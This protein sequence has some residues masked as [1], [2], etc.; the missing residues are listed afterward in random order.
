MI[1]NKNGQ[2][3]IELLIML[4]VGLVV[5]TAVFIMG[6]DRLSWAED[7]VSESKVKI[8]LGKLANAADFVY[9]QSV[10]AASEINLALTGDVKE[11]VIGDASDYTMFRSNH[12]I[13]IIREV[14]GEIYDNWIA[15]A[16]LLKGSINATRGSPQVRLTN[17]GD[18]VQIELV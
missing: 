7:T 3:A 18:F 6:E 15:T 13:T 1:Y 9:S 10:G 12:T 11:V 5:L 16:P 4:S 2:A 8:S 14:G 17:M